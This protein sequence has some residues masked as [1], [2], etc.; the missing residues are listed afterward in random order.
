M[1]PAPLAPFIRFGWA[2]L[3]VEVVKAVRLQSDKIIVGAMMGADALGLYFMAF[4]AGLSLSNAFSTAFSTVIF[5]HLCQAR[6][7]STAFVQSAMLG[8]GLIAPAVILQSL[9]APLYVP[10]LFGAG[11][12][13]VAQIVSIL[14]LVAIPTTLWSAAAGWLRSEGRAQAELAGT[15]AITLG[16]S[17]S[18]VILAPHGLVAV[19]TGYAVTS[20][21]LMAIASL[22]VIL[23]NRPVR[24]QRI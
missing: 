9:L 1:T 20:F 5:P 2:V 14:C 7:K 13:G 22:P 16:L 12:D 3:G 6:D 11:W 19:A 8:V 24:L 4:N 21:A 17:A 15:I 18:T 23:A 10:I